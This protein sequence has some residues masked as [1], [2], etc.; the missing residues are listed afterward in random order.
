M[1]TWDNLTCDSDTCNLINIDGSLPA[2]P[3]PLDNNSTTSTTTNTNNTSNYHPNNNHHQFGLRSGSPTF[4]ALITVCTFVS[5]GLLVWLTRILFYK[6]KYW[7]T[8]NKI[9]CCGRF[10]YKPKQEEQVIQESS[11]IPNTAPPSFHQSEMMMRRTNS[12][13]SLP[14]YFNQDPSPPKYEQAIITQIRPGGSGHFFDYHL[15]STSSTTEQPIWV[16]V[17]LSSTRNTYISHQDWATQTIRHQPVPSSNST[18]IS[19]QVE[20]EDITHQR[21]HL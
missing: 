11:I 16:P 5:I 19:S 6:T 2:T 8:I 1:H 4:I 18:S 14:S 13:N 9:F 12:T 15:P 21:Q 20:E 7:S 17:Y 3:I 10:P